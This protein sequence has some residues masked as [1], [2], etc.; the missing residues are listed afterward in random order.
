MKILHTADWHIGKIIYGEYMLDDQR[1]IL[2]QLLN[3]LKEEPV[4]ALVISGDLYDRAVPPAEAINLLNETLSKIVLEFRIPTIIISGNHDSAERLEFLNRIHSGM[5]LHIEG[6]LKD[7][8]KKVT[9]TDEYGLVN[10]FLLPYVDSF[11]A[12]DLFGM[13]FKNKTEIISKFIEK[14]NI[15]ENERN[16]LVAHEYVLGGEES[17]SERILSIGGSEYIEPSIFE[18]FD[19]V[20][21]G[22]LHRPQNILSQKIC[23]PGSLLKYSFSESYHEKGMNLV[24][25]K[26]KGNINVQKLRFKVKRDMRVIKG[27]FKEVMEK[28]QTDDYLHVILED[29]N[30]VVDGMNKL[31]SRFP[32]VLSLEY[33]NSKTNTNV[34]SLGRDLGKISPVELFEIF[35]KEVKGRELNLDEKEIVKS[36]FEVVIS[37]RSDEV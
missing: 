34:K 33:P 25:F 9:Y 14:M 10:F 6:V 30:V 27:F 36:V 20:A 1:Y 37:E 16:I 18:V 22:H 31:R 11:K 15:D 32:N 19:Y 21:L 24:D 29:E 28:E 12:R 7:E 35:F 5:D 3:Y 13:N 2:T 23:Y 17:E 8:V 26:E 4:D